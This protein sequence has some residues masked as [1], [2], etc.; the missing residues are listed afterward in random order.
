M[1]RPFSEYRVDSAARILVLGLFVV[2]LV[3]CAAMRGGPRSFLDVESTEKSED[4]KNSAMLALANAADADQRNLN[5]SQAMGDVDVLY[6]RYRG[7]LLRTDNIFNASVDLASL[8]SDLAGKLTEAAGVKDNYLTL[9]ALLGGTRATVNNRFLYAQTGLALVKGMDAARAATAL[10]IKRKQ[11]TQTI[12]E[13]TGR[14]AYS[15]VLKYYFDGTLT[16]GL[17]WLQAKAEQQESSNREEIATLSVPT[18]AQLTARETLYDKV[19]A[20]LDK[21]ESLKR[22]LRA[23]AIAVADGEALDSLR[24][25][26]TTE[27]RG[28]LSSGTGEQEL[29]RQLAEA[30]FFKD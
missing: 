26:F 30:N 4:V 16:G 29:E 18:A 11:S 27:Y 12:Q 2:T 19:S 17:I 7:D 10:S 6:V 13:Y 9:G 8:I 3:S 22:A 15:D 25:K 21:P 14:D 28:R 23:W 1:F 5:L 20:H 24:N